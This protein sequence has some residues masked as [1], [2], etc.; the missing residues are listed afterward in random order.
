MIESRII[1]KSSKYIF[2]ALVVILIV[3]GLYLTS[4]YSFLLFHTL[5][6]FFS[7]IIAGTVFVLAW[8]ARRYLANGY[9]LIVGISLLFV[10]I[11][12]TIHT[13]TYSGMNVLITYDADAPT[14]LWIAARYMQSLSLLAATAF[15]YRPVKA[16]VVIGVFGAV[17]ALVLLSIFYWE[18]FPISFID[19]VGLTPF[20]VVSEYIIIA[21]LAAAIVLLHKNRAAFEPDVRGFLVAALGFS[22][23]SE[24]SFTSYVTTYGFANMIGHY[25]KIAAFF[26]FYKAIIETGFIRPYNLLLRDYKAREEAL[27]Q[28]I[29]LQKRLEQKSQ[30][31]AEEA[32]RRASE[33]DAVFQGMIDAVV[34]Y[35]EHGDPVV[36]NPALRNMCGFDPATTRRQEMLDRL[37]IRK[38]DD[39]LHTTESLPS[40]RALQGIKVSNEIMKFD[41]SQGQEMQVLASGSPIYI[42]GQLRGAVVVWH[43]VTEQEQAA[44]RQAELLAENRRQREM[45]ARLVNEAPVGIVFLQGQD[46]RYTLVNAA[47]MRI[48]GLQQ[49]PTGH[50]MA[51]TFPE[52]S[53]FVEALL[54]EVYRTGQPVSRVDEP[55]HVNNS[56]QTRY[57]TYTFTPLF[58]NQNEVDGI[59]LMVNDTTDEVQSRLA[60]DAERARLKAIIETSPVGIVVADKEMCVVLSNPAA[61]QLMPELVP[62]KPIYEDQPYR[63]LTPEGVQVADDDRPLARSIHT[64]KSYTNVE[65]EMEKPGEP[66]R[67]LLINTA[68]IK[69]E[70]G[71]IIGAVSLFQD[72]TERKHVE[73]ELEHYAARLELSNAELQQFAFVVS[74]DLQEPLRKI[75]AF[76]ERL[77]HHAGSRLDEQELD[78]LNRMT[79]AA[80]R[81]QSMIDDLLA[82]SRVTTKGRPFEQVDLEQIAAE[83]LS[84]LEVRIER[85]NG[86]VNI[87]NLP[88]IEADPMQI[89]QLLQNL[90]GNALKYHRTSVPPEIYITAE[91]N[92]DEMAL[93]VKDNGIGFDPIHRERIF[94]P[95][96]RLHGRSAYE[97]TGMGLAICRKIVERHHGR[98]TAESQPGVGTTFITYLPI[99]QPEN[100]VEPAQ[101]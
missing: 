84:D 38:A 18:I 32:E 59:L 33:L 73:A 68:S 88:I 74:H 76:G 20:K 14:Q 1:N 46:H 101:L 15:I 79:N 54:N 42:Q 39:T 92:G 40:G 5:A 31:A 85:T 80:Q 26:Y 22:I 2:T 44:R 82:Y 55:H 41:N 87:N 9:L 78:F 75:R 94:Q 58:A 13:L 56:N 24:F 4:L 62:G 47:F 71:E 21:I 72:I 35:N 17:T 16:H 69:D 12:D 11:L 100:L 97:G 60:L 50:K 23:L 30:Q 63:I 53:L 49:D 67:S 70:S 81:M 10:G 36:S 43:D 66:N 86:R 77:Q 25:F 52:N 29:S 48:A 27:I 28:N 98:I 45:L 57:Y 64:N 95:F 91:V 61:R 83:V 19:G 7:I 3:L 90:L 93:I 51:E 96:E 6:E 99:H 8:N 65:L 89:R 37:K 34:V